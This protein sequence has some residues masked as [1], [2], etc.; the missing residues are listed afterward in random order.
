MHLDNFVQKYIENFCE[1]CVFLVN[2]T[3]EGKV[4]APNERGIGEIS[5][6]ET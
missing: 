2:E 5:T 3:D 6:V 4:N 1:L